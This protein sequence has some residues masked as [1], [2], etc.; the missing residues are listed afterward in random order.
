VRI[1]LRKA[2]H[3]NRAVIFM[4]RF[5]RRKN[6][7]LGE[8]RMVEGTMLLHEVFDRRLIKL[9]LESSGKNEVFFELVDAIAD[10]HPEID[11]E[12]MGDILQKR[13]QKLNTSVCPGTAIPHGYYPGLTK[14]VGAI[15]IS[16]T[17]IDYD[18]PDHEPVHVIFMIVL[19]ESSQEKHLRV[20]SRILALINSGVPDHMVS[21]QSPQEIHDMLF[22]FN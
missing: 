5:S 15:G 3:E 7:G 11:R 1:T 21:A 17:G 13:E 22:R 9:D 18:T 16:K 14:M 8:P 12:K 19:G 10:I 4:T 6:R 2:F 20:L